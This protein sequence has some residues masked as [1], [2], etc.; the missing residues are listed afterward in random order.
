MTKFDQ[1]RLLK[2]LERAERTGEHKY[3]AELFAELESHPEF[4]RFLKDD[5][6]KV[7]DSKADDTKDMSVVLEK[8]H[9]QI[10]M[11]RV[12][13]KP[14]FVKRFLSAFS[15]IAAILLLPLLAAGFYFFSQ[16]RQETAVREMV[17]VM[18]VHAPDNSRIKYILPDSSVVWINS[19]STIKYS[20]QFAANRKIALQGKAYFEATHDKIHP[21]SVSF[22]NGKVEVLGTKFSVT[23]KDNGDFDVTLVEGKV[24]ALI[25]KN[26]KMVILK[27]D[28]RLAVNGTDF[29]VKNVNSR[30]IVAWIEGKLIFRDTP[31]PKVA[32]QLSEWYNVDIILKGNSLKNITY[33]GVFK[34][35]SLDN[36][37]KLMAMTLPV[38]YKKLPR[39]MTGN[40]DYE[41]Q[42]IFIYSNN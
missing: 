1:N 15:K 30:N 34:D 42:K 41:K 22:P 32:K 38:G 36:V 17:P 14:S 20:A 27:P 3:L 25:G 16:N 18:E 35:E 6:N 9:K 26:K 24:R 40:G 8:L 12:D 33:R 5:W 29:I 23:S 10:E 4:S 11:T 21:F 13:D 2:Y 39:K 19:G 7:F 37:L 31:M 28:Q